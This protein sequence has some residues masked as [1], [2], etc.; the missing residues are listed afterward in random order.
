M[1]RIDLRHITGRIGFRDFSEELS[2]LAGVVVEETAELSHQGLRRRFGTPT[3]GDGRPC[4][5]SICALGKF[6]GRELGFGS[7]VEMLFAYEEEGTTDGAASI[8]NSR[9]FGE[10]VQTFL[11]TL[12][13]RREGIFEIDLRLRPY[14]NKGPLAST[15]SAFADYY[16]ERGD[17]R[18]FERMALV[19]LRAVAG[20][21]ELGARI[22]ESRDA[23][24]Y[25]G[26]PLDVENILHLRRRQAS[27]LVPPGAVNAKY[28][29]GGLVEVEYFVQAW[30]ISVG[31][32]DAG[33]RVRNTLNAI[34]RLEKGGH[35]R[36]GRAEGL[37]E[38]YGFLRRLI[39]ALRA[40]RGHARDLTLP[41]ADSREFEYLAR[42]L[43]YESPSLLKDAI[44]ARMGHARAVWDD[45]LP[46]VR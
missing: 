10:L 25:S 9:Y 18:Q 8:E 38:T 20:E 14:G 2:D 21:P 27:E 17:A 29:P 36:Q 6:G 1:F 23:F 13:T 15:L 5:W 35:M 39:D 11:S 4:P 46:A 32:L 26:V 44:T 33:V 7:D 31:H 30:Q 19:K 37:R 40:V 3:L 22:V 16:S 43:Q 24:V 41:D 28:S 12:E 45:G 42:R 34:D